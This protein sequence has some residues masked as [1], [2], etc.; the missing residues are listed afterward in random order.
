MPRPLTGLLPEALWYQDKKQ[1][2]IRFLAAQPAPSDTRR[3]WLL[4]WALWV[5]MRLNRA[6]Y[7]KVQERS[8]DA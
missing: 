2:V 1:E 4:L 7:A 8:F 3:A 6:D 5:G